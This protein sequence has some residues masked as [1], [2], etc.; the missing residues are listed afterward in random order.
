M[1]AIPT[2]C[3]RGQQVGQYLCMRVLKDAYILCLEGVIFGSCFFPYMSKGYT[4][5][6][7]LTF[8]LIHSSKINTARVYYKKDEK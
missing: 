6:V 5:V 2:S 8:D 7:S 3:R 4:V 1:G